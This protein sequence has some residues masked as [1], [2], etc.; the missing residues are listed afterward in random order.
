MEAQSREVKNLVIIYPPHYHNIY[1][2][3]V[4]PDPLGSLDTAPDPVEFITA[5]DAKKFLAL[6]SVETNIDAADTGSVKVLA[7]FF[8]E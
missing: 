5:G 3:W 7:K 2:Y 6:E 1:F 4:E 8:Q